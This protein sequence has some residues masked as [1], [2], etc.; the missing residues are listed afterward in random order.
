MSLSVATSQ[1]QTK[2]NKSHQLPGTCLK[3]KPV[4]ASSKTHRKIRFIEGFTIGD[5][6][7]T[8]TCPTP[9][10]TPIRFVNSFLFCLQWLKSV[11]FMSRRAQTSKPFHSW[12]SSS[13]LAKPT[14]RI[15]EC[16]VQLDPYNCRSSCWGHSQIL[17]YYGFYHILSNSVGW[18]KTSQ[19]Y[20]PIQ[21]L[22]FLQ[23]V[24]LNGENRWE[25]S[26]YIK[27]SKKPETLKS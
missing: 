23:S 14:R 17:C 25:V 9:R 27:Y 13:G 24:C 1:Q 20:I 22:I 4:C 19:L 5:K 16:L 18:T 3:H 12:N 15:R 10:P 21:A 8:G 26:T 6:R 7:K 11:T 2:L